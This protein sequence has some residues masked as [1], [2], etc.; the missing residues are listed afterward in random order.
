MN[1]SGS[2]TTERST[3]EV[4]DLLSEPRQFSPLLQDF[5]SMSMQDATHFTLRISVMAGQITG[6]ADLA[7][8]LS[9]AARASRVQYRGQGIVAGSQ[10]GFGVQ[11]EIFAMEAATEVRWQG[12]VSVDGMLAM[13][14]GGMIESMGRRNFDLMAERIQSR[15][16]GDFF[17]APTGTPL[18]PGSTF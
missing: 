13:M 15:L 7:M 1:H 2:F 12:D 10:I 17:N 6:H 11:F 14:A 3:E 8:E 16:H 9:E 4:F 5:E 18:D